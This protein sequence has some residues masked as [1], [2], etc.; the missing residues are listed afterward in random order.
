M[1]QVMDFLD[2]FNDRFKKVEY[3]YRL[4]YQANNL[5]LSDFP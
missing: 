4:Y 5:G 2:L 1:R 3:R